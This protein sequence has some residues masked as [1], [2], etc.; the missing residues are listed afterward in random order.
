MGFN[1]LYYYVFN[2][3]K[4]VFLTVYCI[5]AEPLKNM[6]SGCVFATATAGNVITPSNTL[7]KHDMMEMLAFLSYLG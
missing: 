4:F 5:T 2:C 3:L 7:L 1:T 6:P